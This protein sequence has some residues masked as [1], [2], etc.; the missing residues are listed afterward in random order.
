MKTLWIAAFLLSSVLSLTAQEVVTARRRVVGGGG[1]LTILH[2]TPFNAGSG[3]TYDITIPGTTAG[4]TLVVFTNSINSATTTTATGATFTN[5]IVDSAY[6]YTTV[7]HAYNVSAGITTVTVSY[8]YSGA[9]TGYVFEIGGAKTAA[10]SYDTGNSMDD[11]Y[12]V[13]DLGTGT[14]TT[15]GAGI[16]IAAFFD[17]SGVATYTPGSGWTG[18]TVNNADYYE[19]RTTAA[20]T[21]YGGTSGQAT[22]SG[23]GIHCIGVIVNILQ[24]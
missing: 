14:I 6:G 5:P 17:T 11:L 8:T 12:N 15:G 13:T 16:A 2:T 20:S 9:N 4:S 19:Y 3:T 7:S 18:G 21:G 10:T 23:T 24:P 1:G 22:A